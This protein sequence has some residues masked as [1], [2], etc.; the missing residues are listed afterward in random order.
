MGEGISMNNE[1]KKNLSKAWQSLLLK[2]YFKWLAIFNVSA[3]CFEESID[4]A[5]FCNK[6]GVDAIAI[7]PPFYY[8]PANDDEL[9]EYLKSIAMNAPNTP[10]IYYHFPEM[11]NVHR[12]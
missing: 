7:L 9:I 6:I 2:K 1:E 12:K 3:T 8:R 4:Q 10:L 11:T 5:K